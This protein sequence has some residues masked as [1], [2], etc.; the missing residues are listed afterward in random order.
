MNGWK[1]EWVGELPDD[2]YDVLLEMVK[3]EEDTQR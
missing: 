3:E 1:Y 2:V